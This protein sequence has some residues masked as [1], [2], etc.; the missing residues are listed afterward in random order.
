MRELSILI[1]ATVILSALGITA[2][3]FISYIR[4][5]AD[6]LSVDTMILGFLAPNIFAFMGFLIYYQNGKNVDA[7]TVS[8]AENKQVLNDLKT[9]TDG[10]THQLVKTSSENA[11]LIERAAGDKTATA[12]AAAFVAAAAVAANKQ[13]SNTSTQE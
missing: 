1:M 9:S 11:T 7:L 8:S 10:M 2:I 12:V 13:D 3:M 4:P 5:N 6:N